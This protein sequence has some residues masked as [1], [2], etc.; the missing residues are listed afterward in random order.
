MYSPLVNSFQGSSPPSQRPQTGEFYV[1]AC[2][3]K[4]RKGFRADLLVMFDQVVDTSANLKVAVF[5]NT[6]IYCLPRI[7]QELLFVLHRCL[8]FQLNRMVDL[9]RTDIVKTNS[10][11]SHPR[12]EQ[13][14]HPCLDK[15]LS[16]RKC[17]SIVVQC[18]GRGRPHVG[19]SN[20]MFLH[21]PFG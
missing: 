18:S 12:H 4:F 11:F 7:I 14:L 6:A 9:G 19:C 10:V 17:I 2:D 8:S 5:T 15:E 3:C 13:L 1:G 20:G 16:I 21:I